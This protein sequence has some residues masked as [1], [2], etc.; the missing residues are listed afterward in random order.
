MNIL[1]VPWGRGMGH[2]TRCLSVAH[3]IIKNHTKAKITIITEEKWDYLIINQGFFRKSFPDSLTS[4]GPWDNWEDYNHTEKS[5]LAD[6]SIIDEV[7]PDLVIIDDRWITVL[8]C[9]MRNV[10]CISILQYNMYPGFVYPGFDKYDFWDSKLKT[11]NEL[12]KNYS[13][14]QMVEDVR[15][16]FK[17]HTMFIPSIPEFEG[18]DPKWDK[19][20]TYV[21]PLLYQINKESHLKLPICNM[22]LIFIY[23]VIKNQSDF[24]SIINFYKDKNYQVVISSVPDKINTN[25]KCRNIIITKFIDISKLLKEC[26]IAI[27]HGGHGSCMTVLEFGIPAIIVANSSETERVLNGKKLEQMGVGKLFSHI[28]N[29][30]T[31]LNHTNHIIEESSYKKKSSFWKR[32]IVSIK[33][34]NKI[35]KNIEKCISQNY[36]E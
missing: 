35:L 5:F 16:L 14:G 33:R 20:I 31:I 18:I 24:D 4:V 19:S 23:G 22:P 2:L 6:I 34:S 3:C 8:A 28:S 7:N 32:K 11:T 15:D 21:G 10:K 30:N 12:I 13:L 27:I 9:E 29:W 17:R 26:D 1:L 25:T 36:L